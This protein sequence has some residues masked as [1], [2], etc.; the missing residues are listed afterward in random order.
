[1]ARL[2]GKCCCAILEYFGMNTVNT[3]TPVSAKNWAK[4]QLVRLGK[5]ADVAGPKVGVTQN[6]SKS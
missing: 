1:M 6:A 4:P 2:R 5:I 3:A